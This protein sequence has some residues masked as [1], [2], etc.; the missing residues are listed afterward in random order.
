MNVPLGDYWLPESFQ[1]KI[2]LGVLTTLNFEMGESCM[3]LGY[4][5]LILRLPS[6]AA[7]P[8]EA[9]TGYGGNPSAFVFNLLIWEA[10]PCWPLSA[11]LYGS[12]LSTSLVRK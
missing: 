8:A 5:T 10:G 2:M 6:V 1:L 7:I 9:V 3:G 11:A 4:H 12:L